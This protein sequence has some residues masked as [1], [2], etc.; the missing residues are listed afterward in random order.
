MTTRLNGSTEASSL[1]MGELARKLNLSSS[2]VSRALTR[3]DKV[4]PE[5]RRRVL[6]AVKAS[7][8][9]PN[10][11]ARSLRTRQMQAIGLV[12][13]DI[14]NPFYAALVKAVLEG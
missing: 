2:T 7:G 6:E 12:V 4:A 9:R 5:T 10:Q 13:S 1:T 14:T 8:Y 11:V 3:P